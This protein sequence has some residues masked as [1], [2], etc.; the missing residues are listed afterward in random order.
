MLRG[1]LFFL[2]GGLGGIGLIHTYLPLPYL[3]L[4]YLWKATQE[5]YCFS[6]GNL[7]T[8]KR[9]KL[10][11]HSI[12]FSIFYICDQVHVLPYKKDLPPPHH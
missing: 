1:F 8:L 2:A 12:P 10:T 6:E 9:G 4:N 11:F 5:I 7:G 3:H